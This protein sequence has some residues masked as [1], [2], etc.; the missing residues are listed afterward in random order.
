MSEARDRLRAILAKKACTPAAPIF[1][2]MSARIADMLGF[3]V[4]KLSGSMV[5]NV[6]LALPNHAPQVTMS[7]FVDVCGRITRVADASLIVD[8]NDGNAWGGPQAFPASLDLTAPSLPDRRNCRLRHGRPPCGPSGC[9]SS[10]CPSP[11]R[12]CRD[13]PAESSAPGSRCRSRSRTSRPG[14]RG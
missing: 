10:G 3:E 12:S 8:V 4:L 1:D 11:A 14:Y 5:A 7:D 13:W 2:P 9:P 6:G